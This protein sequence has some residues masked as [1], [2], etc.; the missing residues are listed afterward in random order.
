MPPRIPN[1]VHALDGHN[2]RAS[3]GS[4]SHPALPRPGAYSSQ[5]TIGAYVVR[6]T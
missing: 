2:G 1:A 5:S 6:L 3:S 4:L